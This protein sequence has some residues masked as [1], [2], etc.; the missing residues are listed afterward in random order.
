MKLCALLAGSLLLSCTLAAQDSEVPLR[1]PDG[2]A[3][4]FVFVDGAKILPVAGKPFSARAATTEWKRSLEDRTVVT[5]HLIA[6]VARDSQGRIFREVRSFVRAESYEHPQLK[7][8]RIYDPVTHTRTACNIRTRRCNITGYNAPTAFIPS[9]EG[10]SDDGTYLEREHLG[11]RALDGLTTVGTGERVTANAGVVSTQEFW[12]SPDL[13][14]NVSSTR[15]NPRQGTQ[16]IQVGDLSRAEPDPAL[17]QIP[18]GF[19]I[20]GPSAK[21]HR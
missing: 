16:V 17:F 13:Q 5:I 1:G 21:A 8:I 12:Y 20:D 10:L 7:G 9:P 4:Y 2:G 15:K 3:N 19:V 11:I 18:P 14:I 6:R